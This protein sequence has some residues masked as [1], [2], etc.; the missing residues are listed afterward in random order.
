MYKPP[1]FHIP[2]E[3]ILTDTGSILLLL[4]FFYLSDL[5]SFLPSSFHH[6]AL[7]D[8]HIGGD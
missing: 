3:Q 4:L 8:L 7:Q 6:H 5:H 2:L 1:T